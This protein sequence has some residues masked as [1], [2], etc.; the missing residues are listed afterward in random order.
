MTLVYESRVGLGLEAALAEVHAA[1]GLVG[2]VALLAAPDRYTVGWIEGRASKAPWPTDARGQALDL[3]GIFDARVFTPERELRWTW[4][5]AGGSALLLSEPGAGLPG[6][7]R[8]VLEAEPMEQITYLL[9]GERQGPAG[10]GW[11]RLV[12]GR[13]GAIEV[14]IA[15]AARRLLLRAVEYVAVDPEHG[16]AFVYEERLL[17]LAPAPEPDRGGEA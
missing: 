9:L 12:S 15:A 1:A 2:A 17:E 4:S 8:V 14:P 10:T 11:S 3:E 7:E 6:W 5:E 13:T 16:N